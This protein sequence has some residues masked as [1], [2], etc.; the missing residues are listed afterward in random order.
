MGP[1]ALVLSIR[2]Q[3]RWPIPNRTSFR[4]PP[5][6]LVPAMEPELAPVRATV[7]VKAM[8]TVTASAPGQELVWATA[9]SKRRSSPRARSW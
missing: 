9:R 2:R 1:A 6:A 3:A 8:E 7:W 4:L 5:A